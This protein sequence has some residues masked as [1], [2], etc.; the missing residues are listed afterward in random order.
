MTLSTGV[1]G[2]T[3]CLWF[4][5]FAFN[6]VSEWL[7]AIFISLMLLNGRQMFAMP[8]PERCWT[9]TR[10][11]CRVAIKEKTPSDFV[12]MANIAN[13]WSCEWALL[14]LH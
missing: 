8:G 14:L 9:A 10:R 11:V 7:F 13:V 6:T 12:V 2:W 1:T 4:H 5:S 3:P